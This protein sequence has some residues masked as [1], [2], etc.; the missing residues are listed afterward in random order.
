MTI[1]GYEKKIREAVPDIKDGKARRLAT[2]L[3]KRAASM[4]EELDFFESLRILGITTD[5]TARD[6]VRNL[7]DAERQAV[8]A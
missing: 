4:Q 2:K 8:A 3:A 7:E 6:A 1:T 5:T